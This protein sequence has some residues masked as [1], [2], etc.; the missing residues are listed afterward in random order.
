[1]VGLASRK[2]IAMHRYGHWSGDTLGMWMIFHSAFWVLLLAA[3]ELLDRRY[4][5]GEIEREEYLQ[6]EKD[7]FETQRRTTPPQK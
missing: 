5:K 1:V 3:L 4:A 6:R 7:I 2:E